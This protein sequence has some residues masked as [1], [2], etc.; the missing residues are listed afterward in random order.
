MRLAL[1]LAFV[2]LLIGGIAWAMR[3]LA[4]G[5]GPENWFPS[6]DKVH[7]LWWFAFLFGLGW[8]AHL[9][10]MWALALG[11]FA[12]GVGMELLQG[13]TPSRSAS[14]T[15]VLADS[16]G[17][18]LAWWGCEWAQRRAAPTNSTH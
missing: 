18:A 9:R 13:L 14:L 5:Q 6:A 4:Q 16:A 15:D 17:I 2:A 3:P 10:P 8:R 7:H 12:Y 1:R 11:L